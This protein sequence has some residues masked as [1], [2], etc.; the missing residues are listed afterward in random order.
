MIYKRKETIEAEQLTDD[1]NS[2]D[3][4]C[5]LIG[6]N[7]LIETTKTGLIIDSQPVNIYDFVIL[8]QS[9]SVTV[10]SKEAFNSMFEIWEG[11]KL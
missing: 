10:F 4:I 9:Y 2:V 5:E 8:D 7:H 6:E 1:P 11:D 3:K